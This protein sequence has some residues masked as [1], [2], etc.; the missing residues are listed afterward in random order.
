M[1]WNVLFETYRKCLEEHQT[2]NNAFHSVAG[3][4]ERARQMSSLLVAQRGGGGEAGVHQGATRA[5][6]PGRAENPRQGRAFHQPSQ[7]VHSRRLT[8]PTDPGTL[9]LWYNH[10]IIALALKFW[11]R[12]QF[13]TI[14][15]STESRNVREYY[16]ANF[17]ALLDNRFSTFIG[18]K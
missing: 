8:H 14:K 1:R 5:H 15:L 10:S 7:R 17:L 3:E 11:H 12:L 6:V 9:V 2:L 16:L 4:T 13:N 18:T